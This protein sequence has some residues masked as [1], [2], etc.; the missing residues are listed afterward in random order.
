MTRSYDLLIFVPYRDRLEHLKQFVPHMERFI[1]KWSFQ[2]VVVEQAPNSPFN[3]G[4]MFNAGVWYAGMNSD[5]FV[6]HD[7]DLLPLNDTCQYDP[8]VAPAHLSGK[9]PQLR[10]KAPANDMCGGVFMI[11][12]EQFWQI[13]GFSNIYWG[14]GQEDGDFGVRLLACD[15]HWPVLPGEYTMLPHEWGG[16]HEKNV[17]H[18]FARR[19]GREEWAGDGLRA[20]RF[21]LR[22][23]QSLREYLST[24][25][26][27]EAPK[28]GT[29]HVVLQID[30]LYTPEQS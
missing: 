5:T 2:L 3:R 6:L 13:D 11:K 19:E 28:C 14:W 9:M 20:H 1:T 26:G 10:G 18:Y 16:V 8:A 27:A 22:S 12:R 25:L 4:L 24:H 21:A 7:V 17:A 30:P 15:I 29:Q 23:W